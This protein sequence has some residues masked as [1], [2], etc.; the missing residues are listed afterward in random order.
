[1]NNLSVIIGYGLKIVNGKAKFVI[2][3]KDIK[4][5]LQII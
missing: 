4:Q 5:F 3:G 2:A 1:M